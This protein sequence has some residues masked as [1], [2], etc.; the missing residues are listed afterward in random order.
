MARVRW[1]RE[2]TIAVA[3]VTAA[4]Y[5]SPVRN[6]PVWRPSPG[7]LVSVRPLSTITMP[8]WLVVG[9]RFQLP[10][11][12]PEDPVIWRIAE[13][14]RDHASIDEGWMLVPRAPGA[15]TLLAQAGDGLIW[16]HLAVLDAPPTAD[17]PREHRSAY[18]AP[19]SAFPRPVVVRDEGTWARLWTLWCAAVLP[20][21][22]PTE[23]REDCVAEYLGFPRRNAL[24]VDAQIPG[25]RFM[26]THVAGNVIHFAMPATW[27][28]V[29]SI[30][31]TSPRIPGSSSS[32]APV[33]YVFEVPALPP[34]ARVE[35][36]RF[37]EAPG[38]GWMS[39]GPEADVTALIHGVVPAFVAPRGV[40]E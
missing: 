18:P 39:E 7:P 6:F 11:G 32:P 17:D 13:R 24:L 5:R 40:A 37:P 4:C 35:F 16:Y 1:V 33:L 20:S 30:P 36:A 14:D 29:A 31:T 26:L 34:G 27:V 9:Q 8:P 22:T 10:R 2:A 19:G 28:E 15:L 21:P 23:S 25:G 3:L 38:H 12:I